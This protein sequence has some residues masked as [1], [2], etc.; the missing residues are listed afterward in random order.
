MLCCG[1]ILGTPAN[2]SICDWELLC[3]RIVQYGLEAKSFCK[4]NE[5]TSENIIKSMYVS[6]HIHKLHVKDC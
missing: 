6:Q 3:A 4:G 5:G 1:N 2:P